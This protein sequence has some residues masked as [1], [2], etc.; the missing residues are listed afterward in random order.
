MKVWPQRPEVSE[1]RARWWLDWVQTF[2][3]TFWLL[4]LA[5]LGIVVFVNS[6]SVH[7]LGQLMQLLR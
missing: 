4:L 6:L 7:D 3:Y 5:A 1:P 2:A